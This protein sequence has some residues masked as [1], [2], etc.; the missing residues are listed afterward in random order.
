MDVEYGYGVLAVVCAAL[1]EYDG[2]EVGA[3]RL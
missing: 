3:G 2:D 1:H